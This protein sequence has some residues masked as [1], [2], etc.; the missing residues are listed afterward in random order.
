MSFEKGLDDSLFK[1]AKKYNNFAVITTDLASYSCGDMFAK[2]FSDRFFN[3]GLADANAVSA[4][5]GFNVRGKVPI[6]VGSAEFLASRAWE[7]I[8]NDICLPNLNV[9]IIGVGYDGID[10][11]ELM[12]LLPNMKVV[13]PRSE[14]EVKIVVE[15]AFLD[16]GPTYVRITDSVLPD[17]E[18]E[19]LLRSQASVL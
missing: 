16:Y 4:A 10:D 19:K 2:F 14:E 12:K 6:V 3:L 1:L 17:F 15:N 7:Q 11:I 8:K 18:D 5:V 9:K 13:C